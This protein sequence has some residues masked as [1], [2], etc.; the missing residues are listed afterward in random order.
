[1][2]FDLGVFY[3]ERPL[4]DEDAGERYLAL[5]SQERDP[6]WVEPSPSVAAFYEELTAK[7]PDTDSPDNPWSGSPLDRS[8][9]HVI[10]SMPSRRAPEIMPYVVET[11]RKY[12]LVC[13]DP[14]SG[15]IVTA[16]T[17]I[18]LS[19]SE[20]QHDR[21]AMNA[22]REKL[23]YIEFME[24]VLKSHGFIKKGR[25]WRREGRNIV[26]A[27][28]FD[29]TGYVPEIW[30]YVWFMAKGKVDAS[31]VG[32]GG[33]GHLVQDLREILPKRMKWRLSH[34]LQPKMYT[35]GLDP[36]DPA[37]RTEWETVFRTLLED[38]AIAWVDDIEA[39]PRAHYGW[40]KAWRR[41]RSIVKG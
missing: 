2:S 34:V 35:A 26:A 7:Y 15:K 6:L 18:L 20:K 10:M 33:H 9:G 24:V 12:G 11:A 38:Y 1:M 40:G 3:T 32:P 27:I 39:H 28:E 5:C 25:I 14:Q 36:Y 17:G 30:M 16:P 19:K 31:T 21:S 41:I 13:F 37:K 8:E 4:R 23:I 22:R 29:D